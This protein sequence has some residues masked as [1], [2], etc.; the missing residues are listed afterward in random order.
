MTPNVF[1]QNT[2]SIQPDL[3]FELTGDW[4][5]SVLSPLDDPAR[6]SS[7][8]VIAPATKVRFGAT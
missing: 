3:G 5:T 7:T 1:Y 2:F 4:K 6:L 8:P